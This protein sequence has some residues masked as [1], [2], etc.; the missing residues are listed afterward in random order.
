MKNNKLILLFIGCVVVFFALNHYFGIVDR[1]LGEHQRGNEALPLNTS[2]EGV[3]IFYDALRDLEYSVKVDTEN[4]LQKGPEDIYIV[5]ESKQAI[6]FDL[7]EAENW[8]RNGGKLIYLTDTYHQ[9]NYPNLIKKFEEKA[10]IYSLGK[11]TMLIGDID[12]ITNETLLED[13]EGAY[14]IVNWIDTLKGN[15][16]FNEHH[17]FS[18]GESPSLYRN[19]PFP[20]K[21]LLL[22]LV[23]LLIGYTVYLGK[24]FGRAKRLMEEVE[25]EENEYLYAAA[26]LYEKGK[27]I[28][29]IY[30]AFYMEFLKEVK[31]TFK[32]TANHY[33]WI[34]LWKKQGLPLEEKTMRVFQYKRSENPMGEKEALSIIKDMNQLTEMLKDRREEGWIKLKQRNL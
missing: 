10:H 26:N 13:R 25:R 1:R 24:R 5:T 15:I 31:R 2:H 29:S 9:Y 23:F 20:I 33:D 19:L 7:K 11:G 8:I 12:L 4:F 27:C 16:Y 14:F 17:R 34:E 18:Q 6:S 21:I 22:Q 28:D 32:T 30:D 3:S